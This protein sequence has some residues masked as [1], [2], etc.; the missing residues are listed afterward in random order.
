MNH[1]K[2]KVQKHFVI[3]YAFALTC[4]YIRKNDIFSLLDSTS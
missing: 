3:T 4:R 1:Q 2:L